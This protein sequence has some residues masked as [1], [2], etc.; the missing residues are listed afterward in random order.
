M[1]NEPL[2]IVGTDFSHC[3]DLAIRA[4]EAIRRKTHGK[5][6]VIHATPLPMQWDWISSEADMVLPPEHYKSDVYR[7]INR[8]LENQIR[9]CETHCTSEIIFGDP[10]KALKTAI[11]T[12]KADLLVLGHRGNATHTFTGSLS[13]K[14]IAASPIPALIMNRQWET[15]KVAGLIDAEEPMRNIYPASEEVSFL[16][17]ADLEYVSL[18]QDLSALTT[19][20]SVPSVAQLTFSEEE[21]AQILGSIQK[22]IKENMDPHSKAKV[23]AELTYDQNL[24]DALVKKLNEEAVDLAVMTRHRRRFLDRLFIGS[25]SRRILDSFQG[26]LLILPPV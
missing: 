4:A 11:D 16:F 6:H 23:V 8:E 25:V 10:Y 2:I 3:S 1:L 18:W 22:M 12:R 19:K 21:R 26:N 17:G 24:A 20:F 15:R 9:R 5:V 7:K 13:A 14:M